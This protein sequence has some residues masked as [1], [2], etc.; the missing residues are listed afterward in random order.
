MVPFG[1][2]NLATLKT[3]SLFLY[4]HN[5]STLKLSA[6]F[7]NPVYVNTSNLG[8]SG[9]KGNEW[10]KYL[11]RIAQ[12][13]YSRILKAVECFD[14]KTRNLMGLQPPDKPKSRWDEL[15]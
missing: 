6:K 9:H 8:L 10:Y 4:Q 7:S 13:V 14:H 5:V 11:K 3:L 15:S 2:L 1:P 12:F